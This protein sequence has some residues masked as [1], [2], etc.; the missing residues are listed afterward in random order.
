MEPT[1]LYRPRVS[2]ETRLLITAG[3][4]AIAALWLLARVRFRDLPTA[5][6][7]IPAVL[8]Q[9]SSGPKLDDLAGEIAEL[10]TRLEASLASIVQPLPASPFETRQRIAALRYR[11]DLAIA[12]L[13]TGSRGDVAGL[14]ARDPASGVALVRV[15][16]QAPA[17][18]PVPWQPRR[19]Q[20]PRYLVATDVSETG[21]SLRPAFIGALVA[22]ETPLWP[23]AL[24]AVPAGSDVAAGSF[25]FTANAELVGLVIPY[26]SGR[27]IVPGA[28]LVAEAGRLR[29]RPPAAAGF[30]GVEVQPLTSAVASVTGAARGV[31]VT[32]VDRAG[33][34]APHLAVGDV[35]EAVGGRA[36][37]GRPDWDVHTDRV[38]E[39]Q[40][41]ALRVRS[42]GQL[43][44]VALVAAAR[45]ARA[46]DRALGLR[47]R[48][49]P[50]VGAEVV[51]VEP[52]S[53]GHRSGLAPGDVIT[54]IGETTAPTPAQVTRSF[55]ALPDDRGV[56]IGVTRSGAHFVVALQ[57]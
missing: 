44:D 31:V 22:I 52:A 40:T 57:R 18:A 28:T 48:S 46:A 47:L 14:L 45:P 56:L 41:I 16:G 23:D 17:A 49:R 42:R 32:W 24:W 15:E 50:G 3:L 9:L 4:L 25:L 20:R 51:G 19:A 27:A 43:R 2:R 7:P 26:G 13:P 39:G 54:R 1:S 34:A 12:L 5:P 21:W 6:S 29:E 10:H 53:A 38:S 30:L 55:A 33:P 35:I 8:G 36:V 37:A 11:D